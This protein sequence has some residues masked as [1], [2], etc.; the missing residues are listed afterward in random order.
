MVPVLAVVGVLSG[1]GS[2]GNPVRS[3]SPAVQVNKA[4]DEVSPRRISPRDLRVYLSAWE[5]SWRRLG[6]DLDRGDE[7]ALGFSFTPDA[8]WE[9]ARR[10][11]DGAATA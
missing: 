8:S 10:L 9:R 2:V 3:D 6:S 5:A 11:Y 4:A 1:C 7:G